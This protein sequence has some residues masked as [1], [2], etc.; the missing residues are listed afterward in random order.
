MTD[1]DSQVA[2]VDCTCQ[3]ETPRLHWWWYPS[4]CMPAPSCPFQRYP[5]WWQSLRSRALQQCIKQ[6][7][8]ADS[9][10]ALID[11]SGNQRGWGL[12]LERARCCLP[13]FQSLATSLSCKQW[14][15]SGPSDKSMTAVDLWGDFDSLFEDCESDV[16]TFGSNGCVNQMS[17]QLLGRIRILFED[18]LSICINNGTV[19]VNNAASNNEY[20]NVCTV[21]ANLCQ[22][23]IYVPQFWADISKLGHSVSW[24]SDATINFV[25]WTLVNAPKS[26]WGIWRR[27]VIYLNLTC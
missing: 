3:T 18:A 11:C 23:R 26:P 17:E 20:E 2:P 6:R 16:V 5:W 21:L 4:R 10:S 19:N 22:R 7:P 15:Q 12:A 25:L 1:R 8:L 14:I 27:W 13:S 9:Q 24:S